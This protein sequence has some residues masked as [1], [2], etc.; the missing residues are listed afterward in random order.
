MAIVGGRA[1]TPQQIRDAENEAMTVCAIPES[2]LIATAASAVTAEICGRFPEA[3]TKGLRAV[4]LVGRGNNGADGWM[5]AA[6][7]LRHGWS[8]DVIRTSEAGCS[9]ACE[10]F[11]EES[12]QSS[13]NA[14]SVATLSD[15]VAWDSYSESD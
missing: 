6:G 8:V 2:R 12:K 9:E 14:H 10:T 5:T 13:G 3:E 11:L 7:L 4:V 15:A 1:Y